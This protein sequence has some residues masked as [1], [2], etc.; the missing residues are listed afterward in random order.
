MRAFLSSQNHKSN[1]RF[2]MSTLNSPL[3]YMMVRGI[4]SPSINTN[5]LLMSGVSILYCKDMQICFVCLMC[6]NH[7]YIRQLVFHLYA[8]GEEGRLIFL[9]FIFQH[10]CHCQSQSVSVSTKITKLDKIFCC[11][12]GR[13]KAFKPRSEMSFKLSSTT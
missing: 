13:E 1:L 4:Q 8:F 2:Q 9:P 11:R 6:Y 5:K 10:G 7:C 3:D 12:S